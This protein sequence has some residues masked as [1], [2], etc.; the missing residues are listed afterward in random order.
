VLDRARVYARDAAAGTLQAAGTHLDVTRRCE[1]EQKLMRLVEQDELT[2]LLNRR[3]SRRALE[4]VH[5][6]AQRSRQP[7]GLAVLDLDHFK[8]VNDAYGHPLGDAVLRSVSDTL[9]RTSRAA[10]WVG[11]W[12]GEEFLILL[13]Q[14]RESEAPA[15]VERICAAVKA[16][17]IETDGARVLVTMSAGL[18][19]SRPEQDSCD[20]VLARATTR[21]TGPSAAAATAWCSTKATL[22]S[23]RCRWR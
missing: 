8:Q 13:P 19:V 10:D 9:Q 11:R 12:G 3:G 20:Q 14:T 7:Y 5:A 1:A 16:Q 21:S 4:R 17:E 6:Q 18:A 2:G 23:S 15:V 22:A